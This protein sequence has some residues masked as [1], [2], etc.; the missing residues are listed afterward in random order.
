LLQPR[1]RPPAGYRNADKPRIKL[2]PPRRAAYAGGMKISIS[3]SVGRAFAVLE[4]FADSKRPATATDISRK[5]G[6]PHS[7]TVAVL[8]NLCELGYL[9][10]DPQTALFFPNAKLLGLAAWLRPAQREGG[11]LGLL[12]ERAA[13]D[14]GHTTVLC[15][16]LAL[17]INTV[18]VRS[19]TYQAAGPSRSVGAALAGSVAG[20]AILAQ[21]ED[22]EVA[23]ILRDTGIW[24]KEAGA[25]PINI[26]RVRDGIE[27][28]RQ[29]GFITGPHPT[30]EGTEII[31]CSVAAAQAA[32]PM[33]LALHVPARLSRDA[34]TDARQALEFRVREHDM[35]PPQLAL[36]WSGAKIMPL[37]QDVAMNF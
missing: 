32:T 24:L 34:K 37:R 36:A 9:N 27:A 2:H 11:K 31:A 21:L 33:A 17:F 15:S 16:R 23:A 12:V 22:D 25:K 14:T 5:L 29:R 13:R 7:S 26:C 1:Y 6:T 4:A 19:G 3:R 8:Y 28:A 10:H 20:I 30:C 35:A 18:A